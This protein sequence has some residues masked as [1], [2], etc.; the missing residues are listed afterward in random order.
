M[1]FLQ[2]QVSQYTNTRCLSIYLDLI[3]VNYVVCSFHCISF[4][5]LWLNLFIF[6]F[7]NAVENGVV[8]FIFT[9][10]IASIWK[11][12]WFFYC[13]F[14]LQFAKLF[15]LIVRMCLF[16]RIFCIA[17]SLQIEIILLFPFQSDAFY[18]FFLPDYPG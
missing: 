9:L 16:F 13:S 18:F 8:F 3:S 15:V 12:S 17:C 4:V 2:Y 5:P 7:F 6:Y 11:D 10:F 1:L 14:I